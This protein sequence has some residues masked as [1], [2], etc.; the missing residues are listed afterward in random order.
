M[1]NR[2]LAIDYGEKRIGVSISDP[3]NTIA[4]SL[5]PIKNSSKVSE[6]IA[7]IINTNKISAV[8]VGYPLNMNGS[9]SKMCLVI[10]EF[11]EK[12]RNKTN[13]EV[14]KYDERLSSKIAE[15][16]I[17]EAIKSKEKRKEKSLIDRFSASIILQE[18]LNQKKNEKN[19]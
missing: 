4:V 16:Q 14:I 6:S 5:E 17:R 13:V 10:D 15:T 7:N 1:S 12:L 8:I 9:K 19:N 2:F 11:I 3:T 18:Y